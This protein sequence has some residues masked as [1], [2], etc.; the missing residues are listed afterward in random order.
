MS[1]RAAAKGP[2]RRPWQVLSGLGEGAD[3]GQGTG[4]SRPGEQVV[5]SVDD[6]TPAGSV[7]LDR[8]LGALQPLACLG[9]GSAMD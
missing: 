3:P 1:P 2:L 5:L 4:Q 7:G 6:G 8:A 9:F